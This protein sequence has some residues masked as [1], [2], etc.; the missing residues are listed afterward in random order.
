MSRQALRELR[1]GVR[2]NPDAAEFLLMVLSTAP[3]VVVRKPL[4]EMLRL[5]AFTA[6]GFDD[7]WTTGVISKKEM[8]GTLALLLNRPVKANP[9]GWTTVAGAGQGEPPNE[10]LRHR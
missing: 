4:G 6:A 10:L 9:N 3:Q 1:D 7:G 2:A 8:A 5:G